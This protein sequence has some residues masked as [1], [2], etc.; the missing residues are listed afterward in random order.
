MAGEFSD[1]VVLVT[2]GASGIGKATVEAF[3]REGAQ[4]VIADFNREA[5]AGVAQAQSSA[6]AKVKFHYCDVRD[7]A[8]VEQ[9][10]AVLAGSFGRLDCAVNSAGIDPETTLDAG[11][12]LETFDAIHATNVRGLFL[13]L[14]GEIGMMAKQGRGTIV[15]LASFAGVR[16]IANK[17]G[18]VA[19]KHGVMGLTRSAALKFIKEGVRINAVCPGPVQ[20]PM[21]EANLRNLANSFSPSTAVAAGRFA[22]PQEMAQVILWLSCERSSYVVGQGISADGGMTI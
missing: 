8:S 1:R 3:A 16:G 6:G 20:T 4:V 11:L 7:P 12:D 21:L 15:N 10:F 14:Q 19:S 17:P 2:G 22:E 5:G 9:L 13:C 18:Y